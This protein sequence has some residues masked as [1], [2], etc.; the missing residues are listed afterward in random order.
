MNY[1]KYITDNPWVPYTLVFALGMIL[2]LMSIGTKSL[3]VDEAYAAGLMEMNPVDLIRMSIAGSPHP[4]L[5]FLFLR[6][7]TILLG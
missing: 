5:A 1:R 7:S 3:W 2:R 4:P 6:F